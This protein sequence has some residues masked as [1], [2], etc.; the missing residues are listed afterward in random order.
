[1]LLTSGSPMSESVNE[2]HVPYEFIFFPVKFKLVKAD[3]AADMWVPDNRIYEQ[4]SCAIWID[5]LPHDNRIY[6]QK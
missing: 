3:D 4:K 6:E 1:M 2:N 5:F